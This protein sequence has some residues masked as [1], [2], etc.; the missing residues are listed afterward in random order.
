MK[1]D[2][3]ST[4]ILRSYVV[5]GPETGDVTGDGVSRDRFSHRGYVK[6]DR[7]F[8]SHLFRPR[9]EILSYYEK[10]IQNMK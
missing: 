10:C 8:P 2:T 1:L 5:D 7:V 6:T 4:V 3:K 9:T